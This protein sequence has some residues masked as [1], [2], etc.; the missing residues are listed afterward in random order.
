MSTDL[1]AVI[2]AAFG[3]AGT[4]TAPI[5]AQRAALRARRVE[6][7]IQ[8]QD[9][10]E[11]RQLALRKEQL[12]E[13]RHVYAALNSAA[14]HYRSASLDYVAALDSGQ[15]SEEARRQLEV[16]RQTFAD[17]HSKAQMSIPDHILTTAT[18]ASRALGNV[19]RVLT[20]GDNEI[21]LVA[22]AQLIESRV[23]E[24]LW[25]LRA[26]MRADLEVS[27]PVPELSARSSG[28]GRPSWPGAQA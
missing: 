23:G 24:A 8:R 10:T 22:V 18:E 7:E 16:A 4:V 28:T 14:R 6:A 2:V 15:D 17:C 26:A 25:N 12:E 20:R 13:R 9:R 11:D 5:F 27:N 21:N 1:S 3:V 19:Y